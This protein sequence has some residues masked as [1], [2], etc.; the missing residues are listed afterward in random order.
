MYTPHPDF[1]SISS[2]GRFMQS[3]KEVES[4]PSHILYKD[5][6]LKKGTALY[7]TGRYEEALDSYSQ[8]ALSTRADALA[9]V[10]MGDCLRKLKRFEEALNAFEEALAIDPRCIKAHIGKCFS[11]GKLGQ[12]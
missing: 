2:W 6:L 1:T 11:Y 7:S 3:E 8:A 10:G 5:E 9:Y 12:F 4:G